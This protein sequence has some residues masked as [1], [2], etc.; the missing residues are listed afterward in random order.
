L[1]KTMA[2]RADAGRPPVVAPA[3]SPRPLSPTVWTSTQLAPETLPLLAQAGIRR[4]VSNRP[5]A[6]DPGQ[7]TAA[8]MEVAANNA[9]L[10]FVWIPVTGL[11]GA[12]QIRSLADALSDRAPTVLFCRSG[13]RSAV[14]WAMSQRLNGADP[15][16]LRAA[17]RAAGYDLSHIPL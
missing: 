2:H 12:G 17:A 7:P 4:I 16:A 1:R 15:D 5:D 11:P 6:E 9:G 10:E 8:E 3:M 14:I 13:T